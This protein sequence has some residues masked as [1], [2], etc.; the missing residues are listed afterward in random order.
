[1]EL[2][3]TN[4]SFAF[5]ALGA[6]TVFGFGDASEGQLGPFATD[7]CHASPLAIDF[8]ALAGTAEEAP[9]AASASA[10]S[11]ADTSAQQ[12]CCSGS[13]SVVLCRSGAVYEWGCGTT[14]RRVPALQDVTQIAVAGTAGQAVAVTAS[15]VLYAWQCGGDPVAVPQSSQNRVRCAVPGAFITGKRTF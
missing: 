13:H 4:F 15:A 12:V 2:V 5:A 7:S 1:M 10:T 6:G 3:R 9:E 14:A 8:A 11:D